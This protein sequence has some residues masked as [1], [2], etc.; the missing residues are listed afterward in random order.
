MVQI[1]ELY[2]EL[3]KTLEECRRVAEKH[4]SQR[5]EEVLGF[6]VIR[7]LPHVPGNQQRQDLLTK[8]VGSKLSFDACLIMV[9]ELILYNAEND[10]LLNEVLVALDSRECECEEQRSAI[11]RIRIAIERLTHLAFRSSATW[12]VFYSGDK[13]SIY[14]FSHLAGGSN[15]AGEIT[16]P[17]NLA[18]GRSSRLAAGAAPLSITLTGNFLD[19]SASPGTKAAAGSLQHL[20]NGGHG[21]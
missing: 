20:F 7:E 10:C 6:S 19:S 4:V 18:G 15:P 1:Q 2:D 21:N 5:T 14:E 16:S 17:N 9:A 3:L 13:G 8:F 11:E 12:P